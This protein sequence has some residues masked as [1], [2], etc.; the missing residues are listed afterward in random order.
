MDLLW[1]LLILQIVV[2]ISLVLIVIK[3]LAMVKDLVNSYVPNP[4]NESITASFDQHTKTNGAQRTPDVDME[5]PR[6]PDDE[7]VPLDQ[8][9]PKSNEPLKV[10]FTE[11]EEGNTSTELQDG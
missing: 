5:D 9:S 8:F 10:K 1:L 6:L 4:S 3:L 7:T 2:V 11:D